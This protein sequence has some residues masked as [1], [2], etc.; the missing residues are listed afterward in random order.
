MLSVGKEGFLAETRM[1]EP[2]NYENIPKG[3]VCGSGVFAAL[4]DW[5]R[6]PGNEPRGRQA[7][8]SDHRVS[9]L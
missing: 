1:K 4:S 9:L 8:G 7:A 5:L 6:S 2:E 3:A